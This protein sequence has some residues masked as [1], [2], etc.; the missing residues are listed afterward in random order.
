M[1]A[2]RAPLE[3]RDRT[4]AL[5]MFASRL[6][7]PEIAVLDV[8]KLDF[9]RNRRFLFRLAFDACVVMLASLT[10]G[11]GRWYGPLMVI[12]RRCCRRSFFAD[13]RVREY[14]FVID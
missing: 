12:P 1:P 14:V 7:H 11:D 2:A 4:I 6:R 8:E 10:S 5:L 3:L 9:K 13:T